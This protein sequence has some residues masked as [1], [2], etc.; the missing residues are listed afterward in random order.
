MEL[1]AIEL[2]ECSYFFNHDGS[3][4]KQKSKSILIDALLEILDKQE[5]KEWKNLHEF[6]IMIDIMLHCR[7]IRWRD[8]HTFQDFANASCN[9]IASI[10]VQRIDFI[11]DLTLNYSYFELS[12]KEAFTKE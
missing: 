12:S 2:G 4:R 9:L 7:K 8:L 3:L 10:A 5:S 6:S 1:S 11:L